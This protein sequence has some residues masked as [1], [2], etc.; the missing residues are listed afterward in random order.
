MA[1]NFWNHIFLCS[2]ALNKKFYVNKS[3]GLLT[4]CHFNR[5]FQITL[6]ATY[7]F[8][9]RTQKLTPKGLFLSLEIVINYWDFSY[10]TTLTLNSS[11]ISKFAFCP[12]SLEIYLLQTKYGS[13]LRFKELRWKYRI[14]PKATHPLEWR[15]KSQC[16]SQE[17]FKTLFCIYLWIIAYSLIFFV[18]HKIILKWFCIF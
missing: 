18:K 4:Q 3:L 17:L 7:L 15:I 10:L 11:V 6:E 8:Q 5:S 12:F 13:Y 14:I 16:T 9:E 2:F 1:E